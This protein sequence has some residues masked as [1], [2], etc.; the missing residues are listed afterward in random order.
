MLAGANGAQRAA[1]QLGGLQPEDFALL[2]Q[3]QCVTAE[4]IDDVADFGVLLDALVNCGLDEREIRELLA[5]VAGLLYLSN[6]Q[7]ADGHDGYAAVS[8]ASTASMA[9]AAQLLGTHFEEPIITRV[10]QN[11]AHPFAKRLDT[12]SPDPGALPLT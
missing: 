11:R 2:Q 4:L 9:S 10:S 6:V 8:K 3:S 12:H 7:F 5:I 1:M